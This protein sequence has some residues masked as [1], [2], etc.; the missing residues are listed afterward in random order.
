MRVLLIDFYDSF[1]FNL[2]H[3]LEGLD[4]QLDVLRYDQ[5]AID[6]LSNY[7]A[8]VLSP[9]PGLPSHKHGLSEILTHL[10]GQKPI[11]GVCLGMQALAE[12]LGAS[13]INQAHVKHG[14][15]EK[16]SIRK[17]TG[18][19]KLLADEINVG[20]YHSWSV[21]CPDEWVSAY[22]PSG[23]PMAI[24]LPLKKVYG[25]QF[26]PES[27]MTPFGKEILLNFI[28]IVQND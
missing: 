20:L 12:H 6:Q 3:Y 26:H 23:V 25:V 10:I 17:K 7:Q 14:V 18:L 19:F 1:T 22:S 8:V 11:L 28:K 13:L 4:V 27:I 2:A 15:Q 24:E 5:I 16:I 21:D 9:G